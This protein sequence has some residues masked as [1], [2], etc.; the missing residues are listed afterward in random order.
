MRTKTLREKCCGAGYETVQNH[1]NVKRRCAQNHT[2]HGADFQTAYFRK[3][4]KRIF[5]VRPV[6]FDTALDGRNLSS[7]GHIVDSRA[8]ADDILGCSA[9]QGTK[10]GC[11]AAGVADPHL[12]GAEEK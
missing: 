2:R 11:R 9:R 3:N 12:A 1:W 7:P 4:I 6:Q 10:N 8:S 5:R